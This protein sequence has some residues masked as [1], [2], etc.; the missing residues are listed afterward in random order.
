M[1]TAELIALLSA[2]AGPVPRQAASRRLGWAVT[3]ALP[4]SLVLMLVA[5]GLRRDLSAAAA[6]PMFWVKLVFPLCIAAMGFLAAQRLARPGMRAGA[7]WAGLLAPVLA[8]WLLAAFAWA[9]ASETA[10]PAMLWGQSWRGCIFNIVLLSAPMFVAV[11]GALKGLA[12]TRPSWAGAAAGAV[13]GGLGASVYALHC[14][15][16]AAPFLAVWYVAGIAVTMALGACLGPRL[17]RW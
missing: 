14:M 6:L 15:E 4:L 17:L 2:D 10:R 3:A 5:Y 8:V 13:A 7:A 11:F 9:G 1:K 16:L 12:P